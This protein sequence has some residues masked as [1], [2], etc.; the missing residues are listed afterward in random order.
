MSYIG[1]L[2]LLNENSVYDAENIAIIEARSFH[3]L[4]EELNDL[5]VNT[6]K[7]DRLNLITSKEYWIEALENAKYNK[8][9]NENIA[10]II[11]DKINETLNMKKDFINK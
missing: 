5:K 8:V 10:I 11:I 2:K 9:S 4:A 3:K 1:I 6:I 7:M